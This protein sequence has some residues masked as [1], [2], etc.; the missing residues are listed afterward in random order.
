MRGV[1]RNEKNVLMRAYGE[2]L[3]VHLPV[4]FTAV[5]TVWTRNRLEKQ[6]YMADECARL[7]RESEL[8]STSATVG[9]VFARN[10]F[11]CAGL[12]MNL[13][14]SVL[15]I[16]PTTFDLAIL[17]VATLSTDESSTM[18]SFLQFGFQLRVFEVAYV[19][20]I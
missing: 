13:S 1:A 15:T 12:N 3:S 5:F 16:G 11:P 9:A 2:V 4:P 19:H 17:L 14:L 7:Q 8:T 6:N 20:Q 10:R 18:L